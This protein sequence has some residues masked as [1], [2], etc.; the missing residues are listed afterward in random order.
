MAP[1]IRTISIHLWTKSNKWKFT[2]SIRLFDQISLWSARLATV[3]SVNWNVCLFR[4]MI[5][6]SKTRKFVCVLWWMIKQKTCTLFDLIKNNLYIKMF[7][8]Y[9]FHIM[10][11]CSFSVSFSVDITLH[12]NLK[13]DTCKAEVVVY[14]YDLNFN[15]GNRAYPLTDGNASKNCTWITSTYHIMESSHM[16]SV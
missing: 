12:P 16:Y 4:T 2:L 5:S 6:C 8:V 9:L 14:D 13:K 3:F 10:R 11:K 15:Q 7:L 1:P